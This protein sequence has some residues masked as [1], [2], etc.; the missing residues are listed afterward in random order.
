MAI[1]RMRRG[2]SGMNYWPGFVDALSTL[3]LSIIFLLSVFVVV[4]FYLQQEVQGQD[5]A[6][7]K[8]NAQV[9]QLSDLL[10][11][12]KADNAGLEKQ[13]AGLQATL[14]ATQSNLDTT[15]ATLAATQ[16]NL[17][18]AQAA[19]A[20]TQSDRDKY[21]GLYEGA[22]AGAAAAQADRDKYKGL[23][24]GA[25]AGVTAAQG[26]VGALTGQLAG[27]KD[28][29]AKALA[30]VDTLN[31]QIAALRQQ[32]AA[33][34]SALD[35]SEKKDQESQQ[36]ISDLGQKLNLALAKDV[37]ELSAYRSDFFGKLR[38]ILGNR[39][40]IRI[41]GDRF[42]LQ[43]EIFF[44]SGSANLKPDGSAEL[45]K[46]AS[47]ITALEG[48][49]PA[50]IPWVLRVDGH[51]DVRPVAGQFKSNWDLSAARAIAVV[52]YLIA[53]GVQP[54]RLV[55]AGFGEFQPI[56]PGTSE[57]AYS[58]NRRIEFKLTER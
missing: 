57:E 7:K 10:S 38:Q 1:A 29:S 20:A 34:N 47:A 24:E 54:N 51:T 58:R 8:L 40:D 44:D 49:I 33:L 15:Q 12:E 53:K 30:Q 4:Q 43:S 48:Q 13:L 42:V 25:A 6:L 23:Y 21:K 32:L 18:T 9:G 46:V 45:D 52:K 22:A 27:E 17:D 5:S 35:I 31:Q 50:D 3:I 37:Q 28:I 39:P 36:R 41:V 11:M 55:A 2:E 56:D 16:S 26:K 14:A 19:L